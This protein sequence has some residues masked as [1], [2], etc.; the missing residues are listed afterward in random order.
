MLLIVVGSESSPRF[1]KFWKICKSKVCLWYGYALKL[2]E[3]SEHGT[4][5]KCPKIQL[6]SYANVDRAGLGFS[7]FWWAA[8][9][10]LIN[11]QSHIFLGHWKNTT[12][13]PSPF[14]YV[15]I[16]YIYIYK[17]HMNYYYYKLL[18]ICIYI[19][20]HVLYLNL[21]EMHCVIQ[22]LNIKNLNPNC[23]MP[24]FVVVPFRWF[25]INE[26]WYSSTRW[27][28][29]VEDRFHGQSKWR[30]VVGWCHQDI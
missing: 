27:P 8:H 3:A 7:L 4:E 30:A 2:R 24:L 10:N 20:T 29:A 9:V 25:R 22:L 11:L 6:L 5:I 18:Y 12:I 26:A 15:Y 17:I 1:S 28:S 19:Y 16:L 14:M 13:W 21:L 23:R